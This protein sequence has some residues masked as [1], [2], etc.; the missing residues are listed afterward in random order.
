MC[1]RDRNISL[2]LDLKVF[3]KTFQSV[4]RQ[5]GISSDTSA[6]M[7]GFKGSPTKGKDEE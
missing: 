2:V 4:F 1:I 6:T 3:F 7:E 5:E